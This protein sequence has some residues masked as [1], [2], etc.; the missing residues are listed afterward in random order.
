MNKN[1]TEKVYL[2]LEKFSRSF[3]IMEVSDKSDWIVKLYNSI[4]NFP[5]DTLAMKGLILNSMENY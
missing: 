2:Y 5:S 1:N 3:P 4:N